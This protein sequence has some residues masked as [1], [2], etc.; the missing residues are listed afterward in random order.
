MII[1]YHKLI[2]MYEKLYYLIF[3]VLSILY[4]LYIEDK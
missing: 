2:I 3:L 4:I 1:Q